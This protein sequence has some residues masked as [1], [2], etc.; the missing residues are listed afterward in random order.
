MP[1]SVNTQLKELLTEVYENSAS[2][3]QLSQELKSLIRSLEPILRLYHGSDHKEAIETRM[4]LLEEQMKNVP[5]K[6]TLPECQR[7]IDKLTHQ[8]QLFKQIDDNLGN[9]LFKMLKCMEKYDIIINDVNKL[10]DKIENKQELDKEKRINIKGVLMEL[11]KWVLAITAA[12]IIAKM[13][14]QS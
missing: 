11:L 6:G 7:Q 5:H 14:G 1:P 12:V 2:I 4:R 9:E 8:L 3:V 10:R 13:A